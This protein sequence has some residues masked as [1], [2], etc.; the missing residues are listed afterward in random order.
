[1]IPLDADLQDPPELIPKMIERW[2]AGFDV[3]L[4]IRSR[5]DE[6]HPVKRFT[7]NSF[8]RL[9]GKLSEVEMTPNAGD[10][11]LMDRQVVQALRKLPERT[12]F[13]KGLFAWLGFRQTQVYFSRGPR[14]V[15]DSKWG[16]LEALEFCFGRFVFVQHCPF[17]GLVL[18][19]RGVVA[20]L[21]YL[22]AI[23]C[24]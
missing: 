6:D 9:F 21:V 2:Q 20:A 23:R 13:M 10:F 1:M 4:A 19:R 24:A 8:Y 15:G 16:Q 18:F 7:A 14:A 22:F 5:R 17:K 3:V 11:R 12:R